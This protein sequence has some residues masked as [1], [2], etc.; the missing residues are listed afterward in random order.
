MRHLVLAL[1]LALTSAAM[2]AAPAP[3]G[4]P[5]ILSEQRDFP[6]VHLTLYFGLGP[7]QDPPGKE[8]LT[9]LTARALARGTTQRGRAELEEA[10][11]ILGSELLTAT[12]SH[13]VGVGGAV[14]SRHLPAFVALLGE[15]VAQPAFDPDEIEK[16]KREM[17]AELE[18]DRDDDGTLAR[19]WFRRLVFAGHPFGHGAAGSPRSLAGIT[20]DDVR[21]HH[22][23]YFGR[24]NLLVGASGDVD[25]ATLQ[26]LLDDA[27]A[28]LPAG[29]K[30]DWTLPPA[31]HPGG[32]HV[33]LID[34]ADRTQAQIVIGHPSLA[35]DDPDF[36][37]VSLG[38]VAFGGTFTARLMQEI[39]VKRGLSYGAYARLAAERGQGYYA[40]T[41]APEADKAVETLK[42]MLDEYDRFVNEGLTDAE[43]EFARGYTINAFP[44]TVETAALRT[45]QAVRNELLG[46]PAD[47]VETF[48][49]TM[50]ALPAEAV[51]DAVRRR[52][53]PQ[54]LTIVMV[55]TAPPLR[56]AVAAL[57]GVTKVTVHPYSALEQAISAAPPTR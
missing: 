16:V 12:Q 57:P 4:I 52:L 22:A 3:R 29:E 46:R 19:M 8:G 28:A 31:P 54:D 47:F 35:A 38:T 45:A 44:F 14:L 5:V 49:D 42:L 7:A 39:R 40:I 53:R 1:G 18:A 36:H 27:L 15:V 48:V 51:R 2:A 20:A 11:E 32:R 17:I 24:A 56:D 41:A 25:Q 6:F 21:A 26:R 10:I 37:A 9:A 55:C 33:A 23:R 13:A 30:V 50:R 34:K 43:I